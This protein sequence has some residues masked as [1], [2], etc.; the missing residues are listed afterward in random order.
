MLSPEIDG[1][2]KIMFNV[3][4][5]DVAMFIVFL[6]V[7]NLLLVSTLHVWGQTINAYTLPLSFSLS[8]LLWSSMNNVR[9]WRRMFIAATSTLFV[10]TVLV[11]LQSFVCSGDYDGNTYHKMAVG[12]LKN[13]WNPIYQDPTQFAA[14]FFKNKN[15]YVRGFWLDHYAKATWFFSASIYAL[16]QNIESGK[17]HTLLSA[18]ALAG[19]AFAY[20]QDKFK[21]HSCRNFVIA[22]LLSWNPIMS[23][24]S[25]SYYLDGC[26]ANY[27]F[28]LVIGLL[29]YVDRGSSFHGKKAWYLIFSSMIYLGNVKLTGLLFGGAFCVLFF[30]ISAW[31]HHNNKQQAWRSVAHDFFAFLLI[32]VISVA[33]AGNSTYLKSWLQD[34]SPAHPWL[35]SELKTLDFLSEQSATVNEFKGKIHSPGFKA[36]YSLFSQ[37]RNSFQTNLPIL[38]FPL[39]ITK[40]EIASTPAVDVRYAGMGVFF[41][42]ILIISIFVTVCFIV[43]TKRYRHERFLILLVNLFVFC[44][45]FSVDGSWIARYSP[46]LY[47]P[48]IFALAVLFFD[49]AIQSKMAKVLFCILSLMLCCNNLYLFKYPWLMIKS[50]AR[51]Q[52]EITKLRGKRIFISSGMRFSGFLFNLIDS[53]VNFAFVQTPEKEAKNFLLYRQVGYFLE[54]PKASSSQ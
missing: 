8:C 4:V 10:L 52:S 35:S 11:A 51:C 45:L 21:G 15:L 41:S 26:L 24:Q 2:T 36:I 25:F 48:V 9:E 53:D 12:L 1:K 19:V 34:H 29:E 7:S 32:A 43:R 54:R 27:F 13:G 33:W 42:G 49:I 18:V 14:N 50:S 28:M 46:Y 47:L 17:V 16:T 37:T 20:L 44:L 31:L 39:M 38:K 23:V 22:T 3:F 5:Y 40:D 6:F 30:C